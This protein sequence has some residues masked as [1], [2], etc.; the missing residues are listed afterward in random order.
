MLHHTCY[1]QLAA[2]NMT[3]MFS[4]LLLVAPTNQRL[5]RSNFFGQVFGT[6][7]FF[8]CTFEMIE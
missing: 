1:V 4:S 5:L 8:T 6:Q 7:P 2:S 3:D